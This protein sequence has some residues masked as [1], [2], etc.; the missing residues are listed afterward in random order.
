MAPKDK[1]YRIYRGG[2]VKGPAGRIAPREAPQTAPERDGRR[3][4]APSAPR[5]RRRWGRYLLTVL[6]AFVLLALVWAVLGYLAFRSGVAEANDRLPDRAERTLAPEQ[7][8]LVSTPANLLLLGVDKGPGKGR[9]G[10]GRADTMML[11]RTDPDANRWGILSIPRD[12]RVPIEGL[13]EARIN[14]AYAQGGPGLA[15]RTVRSLTGLDVHHVVVVDFRRF[16]DVVDAL[17]G[18]TVNV[19]RP[20]RSKFECPRRTQAECERWPGWRF[21]KGRQEMDGRRALIYARVRKNLL[22]PQSSDVT[23]ISQQQQVVQAIADKAVSVETFV[24]LPFVGDD[25]VRPLATDLSAT[26]LVQL[27]WLERRIPDDSTVRCRLGGTLSSGGSFILAEDTQLVVAMLTGDAAPQP[28]PPGSELF[29]A[30]CFVGR[31]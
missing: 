30:G 8:S 10:P 31:T 15:V 22:D 19:R 28:P 20:I 1:P 11:L 25:L 23:R 26:E 17:G 7:G 3:P 2:R 14:A 21:R 4:G 24:R 18:I 9:E 16:R 12:L 6:L 5:R 29:G 27:A 13:G